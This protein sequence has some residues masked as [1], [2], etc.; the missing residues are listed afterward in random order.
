MDNIRAARDG[1]ERAKGQQRPAA[2]VQ[3]WEGEERVARRVYLQ[4]VED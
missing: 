1:L 4:L 2:E 3:R